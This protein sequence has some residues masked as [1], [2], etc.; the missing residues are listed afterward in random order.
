MTGHR[1][2]GAALAIAVT[3]AVA[4]CGNG[5]PNATTAAG[6]GGIAGTGAKTLPGT[7]VVTVKETDAL[8]FENGDVTAKVN[9]VIH[10]TN[11]GTAAHNVKFDTDSTGVVSS[12]TMAGGDTWDVKFTAPGTFAYKCSFHAPGM[13][14]TI[15]VS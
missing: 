2:L 4:G 6:G 10:F 7:P 8:A 9:D 14:G 12:G 5:D 3:I 13:K 15:T 1:S 11:S